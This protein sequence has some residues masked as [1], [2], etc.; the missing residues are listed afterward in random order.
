[1]TRMRG[2]WSEEKMGSRK[3]SEQTNRSRR[4][5]GG[6]QEGGGGGGGKEGL[7]SKEGMQSIAGGADSKTGSCRL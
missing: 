6:G 4:A 1:M 5:T 7:G 2:L 3:G